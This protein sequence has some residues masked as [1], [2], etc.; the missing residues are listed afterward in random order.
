MTPSARRLP[1]P[2]LPE[3]PV[4]PAEDGFRPDQDE[5]RAPLVPDPRRDH[6]EDPVGMAQPGPGAL[7]MK[8][9][10]L[11]TEGEIFQSQ[12]RA[13][14]QESAEEHEDASA[15]RTSAQDSY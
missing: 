10:E 15:L 13:V 5:G 1:T 9:G 14:P 4:A 6:P 11:L 12:A 2:E 7:A 8:D 3:S